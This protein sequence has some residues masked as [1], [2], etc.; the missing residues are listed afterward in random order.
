MLQDVTA[1]ISVVTGSSSGISKLN[2]LS[3]SNKKL[4][5]DQLYSILIGNILLSKFRVASI[6]L[7]NGMK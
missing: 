7:R 5:G 6:F 1:L 3:M 2:K 4:S